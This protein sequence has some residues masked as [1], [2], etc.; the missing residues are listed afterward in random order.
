MSKSLATMPAD[1]QRWKQLAGISL[2]RA[3]HPRLG[4]AV[5]AEWAYSRLP[6]LPG[7]AGR[8]G[9]EAT[10]GRLVRARTQ[11]SRRDSVA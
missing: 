10:V 11:P 6:S 4:D 7:A 5:W 3:G 8:Y 9:H 2:E 1:L